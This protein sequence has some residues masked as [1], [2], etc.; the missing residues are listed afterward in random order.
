LECFADIAQSILWDRNIDEPEQLRDGTSQ[1]SL[2]SSEMQSSSSIE[3]AV[4]PPD[5]SSS[6]EPIQITGDEFP[7]PPDD[8]N[9]LRAYNRILAKSFP[10]S[11]KRARLI[12]LLSE[13]SPMSSQEILPADFEQNL[14]RKTAQRPEQKSSKS[15]TSSLSS[16]S[17]SSPGSDVSTVQPNSTLPY[18]QNVSAPVPPLPP[19]IHSNVAAPRRIFT[20]NPISRR[21]PRPNTKNFGG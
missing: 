1:S 21:D 13:R 6:T 9:L 3:F 17:K 12:E 20:E 5:F 15:N 10:R 4:P 14:R 16:S 2:D 8:E 7:P 19:R 11:V 18:S